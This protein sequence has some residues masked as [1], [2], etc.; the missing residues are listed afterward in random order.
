MHAIAIRERAWRG[1]SYS[2]NDESIIVRGGGAAP[3]PY[4]SYGPAMSRYQ[5]HFSVTIIFGVT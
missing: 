2:Y 1:S 4:G 5:G 3:C